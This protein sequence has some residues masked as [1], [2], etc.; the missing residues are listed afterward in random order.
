MGERQYS[1][2]WWW[3]NLISTCQG[4][5]LSS[6]QALSR[7]RLFAT[8]WTA[9]RQT[10]CSSP[11]PGVYSKSCPLCWWC[12]PPISSSVEPL[13]SHLQ[14]FAA[15]GSFQMRQL[16]TS[17]GQSIGV[18]ASGSV[19]PPNIQNWLP[20]GWTGWISLKF[21]G[22]SKSSPTPQFKSINSL[23]LKF[24]YNPTLTSINDY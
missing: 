16:F 7:V 21:K 12:H 14:S 17:G 10:S 1:P 6:A 9:A 5:R 2:K 11:T 22:L 13:C 24:L 3:E 8:P 23:V 18:S 4:M 15:S 19:L 20:L